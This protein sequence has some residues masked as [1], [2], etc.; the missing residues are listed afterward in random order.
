[1][2]DN[3]LNPD[4]Q[5][6]SKSSDNGSSE[7]NMPAPMS[8]EQLRQFQQ[9]QQFQ[10]FIASQQ[11]SKPQP[12]K[13]FPR[14]FKRSAGKILSLF[15]VVVALIIAGKLA[16]SHFF[17]SD[18]GKTSAE[19]AQEG[20]GTFHTN[21][22]YS[23]NPYEAVW[24]VYKNVAQDIPKD[25]CNR[26]KEGSEQKFAANMGFSDCRIAVE[27][28]HAKVTHQSNY[29]RSMPMSVSEPITNDTVLISS[30]KFGVHDGPA[31]GAFI[32]QKVEKGQWIIV[33]HQKESDP[34]PDP[35]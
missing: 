5:S 22:L 29:A 30:C 17:P 16:Y 9:Y 8:Q 27:S 11:A 4:R 32:V 19:V 6:E 2:V 35:Q 12:P 7:A 1:M 28:L 18:K 21:L 31:L 10:A 20:G 25:A 33:D 34:C 26:F 23:T 3:P 14:W 15:L 13:P 24:F